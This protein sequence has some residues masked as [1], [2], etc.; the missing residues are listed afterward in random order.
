[1]DWNQSDPNVKED[2]EIS[3][4][5]PLD[6]ILAYLIDSFEKMRAQFSRCRTS[7]SS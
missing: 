3:H 7:S 5:V 4:D 2:L 6:R 1:M